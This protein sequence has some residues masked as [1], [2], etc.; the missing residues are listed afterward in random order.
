MFYLQVYAGV[1]PLDASDFESLNDAMEKLTLN[2]ASV[3]VQK[4]SSE[5]LGMGFRFL[6]R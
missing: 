1:Y 3:P 4:E 5:A 2:D 6:L